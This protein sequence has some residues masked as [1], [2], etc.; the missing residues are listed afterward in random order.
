MPSY[1]FKAVDSRGQEVVDDV[2]A[3]STEE[4]SSLIKSMGY[5]PTEIR[6]K[7]GKAHPAAAAKSGR[8]KT[9]AIGGVRMRDMAQFTTQMSILIDAGLPIVRSLQ[10][11]EEQQKPGVLKNALMDISDDVESGSSLSDALSRHSKVFDTLY[12]N[13]VRAGEA[14][15]V[16]DIILDRLSKFLERGHKLRSTVKGAMT[17]PLVIGTV[18]FLI[19]MGLMVG[20][21]PKFEDMFTQQGIQLPTVTRIVI[22]ASSGIMGLFGVTR[23]ENNFT[24]NPNQLLIDAVVLAGFIGLGMFLFKS[25]IGRKILDYVKLYIPLT[26]PIVRKST[27]T[28]FCRTLGTTVTVVPT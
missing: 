15:G 4:A 25:R 1:T 12:V 28:R 10:I 11:L 3:K 13:M 19:L 16:L 5:F 7:S 22:K 21:V 17:Y 2:E 26:G 18:A 14:G 8:K 23:V 6:P 20:V 9:W 24:F 27:V